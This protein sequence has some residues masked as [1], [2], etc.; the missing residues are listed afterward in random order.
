MDAAGAWSDERRQRQSACRAR[1]ARH[2]WARDRPAGG[3]VPRREARRRRVGGQ[4]RRGDR[5]SPSTATRC[6]CCRRPPKASRPP[7]P[8]FCVPE[9]A[10]LRH[11]GRQLLARVW[12]ARQRQGDRPRG[13]S[14]NAAASRRPRWATRPTGCSD[15]DRMCRGIADLTPMFPSGQRTAYASLNLRLHRRRSHPARSTAAPSRSFSK[16][17]SA[18]RSASTSLTSACPTAGCRASRCSKTGRRR[19]P[20]TTRAWWASPRAVEVARYF[21]RREIQQAAIPGLGRYHAARAGWRGTT[22]C[23]PTGG[24]L[25]GVR[26]AAG[27][28]DPRRH[29]AAELR[30][31][32]DLP[33]ARAARAR[34]PARP[35]YRALARPTLSATSA[36]GLVRLRRPGAHSA[37]ASRRTTSRMRPAAPSTADARLA[38]RRTS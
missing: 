32:R 3:R 4:G 36:A 28:R 15:W 17:S 2:G 20:T 7:V 11:A 14:R 19:R 24:E 34:L 31:G 13:A 37:S 26:I 16:R 12:R 35:R 1:I 23:W 9:Q 30:V 25:D 21:N 18:S 38:R 27:R 10:R 6:S 29:R 5:A 8:P 33:R 22:R